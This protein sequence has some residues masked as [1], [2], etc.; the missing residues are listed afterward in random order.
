M[1]MKELPSWLVNNQGFINKLKGLTISSVVNQFPSVR[2]FNNQSVSDQDIS[3]LLTCG[4]VLSQS[5]DDLCQD[6]ALRISQYCLINLNS[7]QRKDSAALILDAL[8]NN[9]TVE[10][11]VKK[12]FLKEGFEKRLPIAGQL[13]T[14][15]RKIEHTIEIGNDK[16]IYANKFQSEFWDR[17]QKNEWVSVSAPTSVGKSF[18]LESWVEDYINKKDRGL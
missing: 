15:K 7:E 2:A 17:V 8:A 13:E 10:L 1:S 5:N 6:A 9:A 12:G 3:Y 16:L 18:I 4:S 11:A 14:T